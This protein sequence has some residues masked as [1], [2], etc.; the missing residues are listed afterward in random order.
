[1]RKTTS[2]F[3]VGM[4]AILSIGAYASAAEWGSLKG[5]FVVDGEPGK[6]APIPITKDPEYCGTKEPVVDQ[7]VVV[8]KDNALV[9][10]VVYLR[11]PFGKKIDINPAYEA[12]LKK[13]VVLDN[14]FCTFHPHVTLLRLGQELNIK[15]S[16]PVGHNT[17]ID[18]FSFNQSIGANTEVKVPDSKDFALPVPISCSMHPWMQGH[19][20]SLNH[21]YMAASGEDGTFEIKDMPAGTNEFQFWHEA[22]GY[23]KDL[24]FKGGSTNA[25]GRAKLTIAPGQT[26]DLGDIKVPSRMLAPK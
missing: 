26:L 10:G 16:D 24:K 3:V 18:L 25:Q 23:M 9:N 4:L 7:T 12:K 5:R 6:P 17:K 22:R 2:A 1:M 19:L 20:L 8:G 14:H 15:N 13:P 11:A 21:P